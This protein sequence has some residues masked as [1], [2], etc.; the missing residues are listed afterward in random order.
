MKDEKNDERAHEKNAAAGLSR[1]NFIAALGATVGA[2]ALLERGVE[3]AS[4]QEAGQGE[5]L[6]YVNSWG[7]T[8]PISPDVVGIGIPLPPLVSPNENPPTPDALLGKRPGP[9]PRAHHGKFGPEDSGDV[10]YGCYSPNWEAPNILLIMVDQLR[11]PRWLSN[12]PNSVYPSME[13]V[14]ESVTPTIYEIW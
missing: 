2:G 3:G 1:R 5:T 10:S 14:F 13:T 11:S 12:S 9:P 6:Y 4:A 8:A 7:Q